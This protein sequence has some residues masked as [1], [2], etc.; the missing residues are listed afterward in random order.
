M[1]EGLGTIA[2]LLIGV[3]MFIMAVLCFLIPVFI[4]QTAS[5]TRKIVK[6][7]ENMQKQ[8]EHI[9]ARVIHW[10]ANIE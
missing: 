10:D 4:Y 2:I 6:I 9:K 1:A 7:A 8:L 5:N 3:G